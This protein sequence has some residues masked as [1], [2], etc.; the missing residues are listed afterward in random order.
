MALL[1][2]TIIIII[3]IIIIIFII[4]IIIIVY[5]DQLIPSREGPQQ[6]DPLSSLEV[7][8]AVQPILKYLSSDLEIGFI[9]DLFLSADL[10]TLAQDVSTIIKAESSTGLKLNSSK[11]EIIMKDFS[12]LEH[13]DVFKDFIRVPKDN[14]TLLGAP[15]PQGTALDKALGTKCDDLERA[16]GRLKLLRA[17][18]ALVLLKN[19]ISIPKLLYLLRTSNCFN[20]PQLLKFDTVLKDGLSAILSVDYNETQWMQ[21]ILPVKDGGLGIRCANTLA[22]SAFLASAVSTHA[23]QQ[24]I[25]PS[26]HSLLSYS[27]KFSVEAIWGSLSNMPAPE[28]SLQH[29]QRSWDAPIVRT[30]SEVVFT[31]AE[32][33]IDRA[34]LKAAASAH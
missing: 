31:S 4:I 20:H 2:I 16:I 27:D 28:P 24:S 9:D 32:S 11:C 5:G 25:I 1:L 14:L 12:Q 19:S 17:H 30:L 22:T 15:I 10:L 18:D 33:E 21:A 6:G 26:S 34:R 29:I 7:C 8:E 3:I 23:L 13:L